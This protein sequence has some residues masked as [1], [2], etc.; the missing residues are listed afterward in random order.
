MRCDLLGLIITAGLSLMACGEG[1]RT[2]PETSCDPVADTQCPR[3]MHCRLVADGRTICLAQ[4]PALAGPCVPGSCAPGEACVEL[5]GALGCHV[6][7]DLAA[8]DCAGDASCAY[9]PTEDSP[10]G[11]CSPRCDA[12]L[13][14]PAGQTCAPTAQLSHRVCA[15]VGPAAVGE[16]C[17]GDTR[18]GLGLA[19]LIDVDGAPRCQ[20][21]CDPSDD[22]CPAGVCVGR[23]RQ[24]PDVGYCTG[25]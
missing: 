14:C 21:L 24:V 15:A 12:E 16:P 7:C 19:C 17:S 2:V 18:C 23:V 25:D 22:R 20:R 4:R 6:V 10:W 8:P 13:P 1:V 9:R 3:D 5:E 11:L